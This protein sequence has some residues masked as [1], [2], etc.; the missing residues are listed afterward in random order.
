MNLMINEY[1]LKHEDIQESNSKVRAF[2]VDEN[3]NV[4][5]AKY[6]NVILL[7]GGSINKNKTKKC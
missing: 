2:L 7:P 3:N 5:I 4:L 1:N 6:G